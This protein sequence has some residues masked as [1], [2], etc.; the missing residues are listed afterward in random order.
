MFCHVDLNLLLICVVLIT[1]CFLLD[2]G[3]DSST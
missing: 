2:I 1:I 3:F